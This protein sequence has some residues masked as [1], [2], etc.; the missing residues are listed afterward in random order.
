M[1]TIVSLELLHYKL[2]MVKLLGFFKNEDLYNYA[3]INIRFQK[4][5]V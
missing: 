4:Q 2:A 5:C 3:T 1:S